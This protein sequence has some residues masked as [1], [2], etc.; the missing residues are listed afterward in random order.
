MRR[1][2]PPV[3]V[4]IFLAFLFV[5]MELRSSLAMLPAGLMNLNHVAPRRLFWQAE[6]DYHG[7]MRYDRVAVR[8]LRR[9]PLPRAHGFHGLFVQSGS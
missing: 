2:R 1:V 3:R 4:S 8:V 6:G 9:F 5:Q 7:L